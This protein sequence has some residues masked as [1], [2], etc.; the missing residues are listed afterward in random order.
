MA[1]AGSTD[2]EGTATTITVTYTIPN[3]AT[4]AIELVVDS[5]TV[6][7]ASSAG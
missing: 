3:D 4:E 1:T 2:G 5:V 6:T 7:P